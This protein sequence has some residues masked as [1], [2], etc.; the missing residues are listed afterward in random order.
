MNTQRTLDFLSPFKVWMNRILNTKYAM[1][2]QQLFTVFPQRR[3]VVPCLN[4]NNFGMK[5]AR[6]VSNWLIRGK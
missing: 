5:Y 1:L 2:N 4:G 3:W 6:V